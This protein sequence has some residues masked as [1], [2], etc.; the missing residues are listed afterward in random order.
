[1]SNGN[2]TNQQ[3]TRGTA[4]AIGD[5]GDVGDTGGDHDPA[6]L[7]AERIQE[8]I[9]ADT[10]VTRLKAER[11]QLAL[12]D[13]RGWTIQRG[14]IAR[15]FELADKLEASRLLQ[16]VAGLDLEGE[17]PELHLR[18]G[19]VTLVLPTVDDAYLEE[20]LYEMAKSLSAI[21]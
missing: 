4:I 20:P 10:G 2:N 9:S 14:G 11:I 21:A 18:R 8:A 16:S 3:P 6:G 13:L 7:K 12:R 5:V 15:T 19:R 17:M 1:M